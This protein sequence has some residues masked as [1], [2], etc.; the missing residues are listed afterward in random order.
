MCT[1]TDGISFTQ[2]ASG[3][4]NA[5]PATKSAQWAATTAAFVRLIATSATGSYANANG[6]KIGGSA[7]PVRQG[8]ALDTSK[9]Y[10]LV[11]R[12][13]G[14]VLDVYGYGKADGTRVQ[15]YT[16]TVAACQKFTLAPTGDGYFAIRDQNSGKLVEIGNLSRDDGGTANIWSAADVH[17]Q[18]WAV[19]PLAGGYVLLTNRLS[20]KMLEVAGASTPDETVADQVEPSGAPEQQWQLVTV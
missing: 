3:A 11:N 2:V 8:Y 18:H 5:G 16:W 4:W 15:Q 12:N 19:T 10:R 14:K 9:V 6:L 20:G 17:Q 1:S 7:R 13:S